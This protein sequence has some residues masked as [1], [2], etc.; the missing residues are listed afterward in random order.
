MDASDVL[1]NG[2]VRCIVGYK[3]RSNSRYY[4]Q[5]SSR[6]IVPLHTTS[7]VDFHPELAL[8]SL[9]IHEYLE[10]PEKWKHAKAHGAMVIRERRT[11]KEHGEGPAR[12]L[13]RRYPSLACD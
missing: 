4:W 12:P 13:I 3:K 2:P 1:F 6:I 9:A 11:P 8:H 10:N 5:A 7:V